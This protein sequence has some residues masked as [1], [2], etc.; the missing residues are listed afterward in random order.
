[1]TEPT[2]EL[3]IVVPA[4]NEEACL[5]SIVVEVRDAAARQGIDAELVI[6]DDGSTD[7]TPAI[8]AQ[9]ARELPRVRVV[10]HA[11][12][13]GSGQ[14]IRTGLAH[15]RGT[16]AIYVPADGQFDLDELS[17]Y[18]APARAGADIVIGARLDRADYTPFRLLSSRVYIALTNALFKERFRDVNWVHLWRTSLWDQIVPRSRGVYFLDEVLVRARRA[19]RRI[20]EVDSRYLPRKGGKATGS[21]PSVILLTVWEMLAFRAH[22]SVSPRRRPRR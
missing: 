1:L 9:L 17:K 15:A 13:Q 16:F 20:V 6:V 14:A 4:Y 5:A 10:R 22:L 2:C 18:L 21:R 11:S 12:N 3:S 19:G 8:S 7:G